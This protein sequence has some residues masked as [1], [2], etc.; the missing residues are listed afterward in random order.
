M[1]SGQFQRIAKALA[2][3]RRFEILE[4]IAAADELR[5][6]DVIRDAQVCQATVSHHM[7]ELVNAGLIASRREAKFVFFKLRRDVWAD[8]LEA[9]RKRVPLA[10]QSS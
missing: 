4:R 10:L 6:S 7:K 1:E 3:P 8:Y 5:C 9:M 2:D